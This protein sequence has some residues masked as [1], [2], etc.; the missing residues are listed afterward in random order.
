MHFTVVGC[1]YD[2]ADQLYA[3][4]ASSGHLPSAAISQ[5]S[6]GMLEEDIGRLQLDL[7]GMSAAVAHAAVRVSLQK[8][9]VVGSSSSKD[10]PRWKRDVLIITG[11][12]RRS[13]EPLKPI[14]RPEV[15]RMLTEEFYPPLT[16]MSLP[17]NMGALLVPH[18]DIDAWLAHQN[19]KKDERLLSVADILRDVS[20]GSRLE[21]ALLSSG[22]RLEKALR[23]KKWT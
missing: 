5:D 23:K 1:N 8:E 6:R 4:G 10:S 13:G 21:R 22:N 19:Q 16:S 20:S 17:K 7:H 9:I 3:D 14:L 11:R 15:Q 2:E 18:A 12:G